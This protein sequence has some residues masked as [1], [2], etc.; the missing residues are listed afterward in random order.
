MR[1]CV[2]ST[3]GGAKELQILRIAPENPS[4]EE[5][6]SEVQGMKQAALRL[7]KVHLLGPVTGGGFCRTL[8]EHAISPYMN[9]TTI[10][11]EV[12]CQI[13]VYRAAK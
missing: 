13:C 4:G 9:A 8:C 11:E 6:T 5:R 7:R 2:Q 12:T 10:Q 1:G 3:F